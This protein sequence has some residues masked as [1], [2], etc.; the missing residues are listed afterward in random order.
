MAFNKQGFSLSR[1]RNSRGGDRG[2]FSPRFAGGAGRSRP[3]FSA[4]GGPVS[5]WGGKPRFSDRGPVE[6]HQAVC[7][8]CGKNCEVPFRPTQGKPIFCSNCFE[9]QKEGFDSRFDNRGSGR[10]EERQV[11]EAVCADCGDKCTVPFH[12]TGDKPVFCSN[13][14]GGKKNAGGNTNGAK[15]QFQELHAKLDKILS[16]LSPVVVEEVVIEKPI[17]VKKTKVNETK[18][19]ETSPVTDSVTEE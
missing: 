3:S 4:K 7:D 12:P 10:S 2:G 8:N 13:C 5:G 1:D 15:D 9:S 11:F 16:I 6:M 14:F 17:K 19:E 18:V